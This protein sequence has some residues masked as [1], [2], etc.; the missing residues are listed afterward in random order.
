MMVI[1]L[2]IEAWVCR[3]KLGLGAG[4]PGSRLV[5]FFIAKKVFFFL[6]QVFPLHTVV[7]IAGAHG[8]ASP[9]AVQLRVDATIHQAHILGK[10]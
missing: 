3:P 9:N 5:R 1:A 4:I 6:C 7:V 2:Y 10:E 8:S